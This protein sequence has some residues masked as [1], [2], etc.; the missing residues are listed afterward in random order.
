[1]SMSNRLFVGAVGALVLTC[2][3]LLA[4]CDERSK[5]GK[6]EV[7]HVSAKGP[8]TVGTKAGSK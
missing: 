5:T 4:G 6:A 3:L 7:P 2:C 1:M 8:A